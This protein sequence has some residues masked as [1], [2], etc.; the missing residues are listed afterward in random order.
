MMGHTSLCVERSRG[1]LCTNSLKLNCF[2]KKSGV[3][4]DESCFHNVVAMKTRLLYP[5]NKYYHIFLPVITEKNTCRR[6]AIA[7]ITVG[8][9]RQCKVLLRTLSNPQKSGRFP[10]LSTTYARGSN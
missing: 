9:K 7:E 5:R 2:M 3:I 4:R 1:I 6:S 8:K 10:R